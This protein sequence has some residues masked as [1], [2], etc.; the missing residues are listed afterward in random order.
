MAKVDLSKFNRRVNQ[1]IDRFESKEFLTECGNYMADRIRTRT[2]LG[3]GVTESGQPQGLKKLSQS[4]KDQ[5]AGKIAF[6]SKGK[7][8]GRIIY[9]YVPDARPKL[10]PQTSP[11]KSNLTFTGQM[12]DSLGITKIT[13]N[14]V[15]IGPRGRR[16]D[17]AL[18]NQDVAGFVSKER[19]F[20]NISSP[21]RE[22]LK[23]FIGQLFAKFSRKP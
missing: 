4:Y 9:P 1:I 15:E 14:S 10:H 13:R 7:G 6:A 22:G 23:R 21:E 8:A 3:R 16:T 19:P 18:S 17:S 5:R 12:L 20:L 11:G 2:R